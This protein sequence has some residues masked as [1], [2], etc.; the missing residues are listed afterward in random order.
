MS[1]TQR[2]RIKRGK[3]RDKRT[4]LLLLLLV[5]LTLL[6]L[7][8]PSEPLKKALNISADGSVLFEHEGL[9]IS[10][11]MSVNASALPDENGNFPD[12]L[13]LWNSTE[14]EMNLEGISLSN[15]SDKA[16]FIFPD[17]VLP[18]DGRV[19]IYC[20]K[21]NASI[22]GSPFHAKFK[23]SSLGC[24][25]FVFDPSGF[26]LNHVVVPTL[27]ANDSYSLMEDGSF[28][29]VDYYSPG[30][31][32]TPEGHGQYMERYTLREGTLLI[33]E[34]IA[35]P[36][37]GF[38]D[39]DGDL[40]DW[41]ELYNA[42]T[43]SIDLSN[44]ALSDNELRPIKWVFPEGSWI[45]PGGYYLV[46]CSGKNKA[47]PSAFPH[48][49]FSIAA[50]GETITLSSLQGNLIDRVT[51]S[52]LPADHSYG[53]DPQTGTW[54]VFAIP[55]PGAPNNAD[56][57]GLADRYLRAL[58]ETGVYVSELMSSN[59]QTEPVPGESPCDWVEL[60]NSSDQVVDL[61]GFGLS[62]SISWP[63]RWRFPA[64]VSIWPGE[65][66]IVMLDKS[67]TPGTNAAAL[68]ASFALKRAGG[69]VMT[70]SNPEGRV[71][72]R[73]VLPEIPG[74]ISYGR[75]IGR[76]GFFYYDVP[77]PG[78]ANGI[79]FLGFSN[80]PIL[81]HP[82]GLYGD[83]ILLTL[84]GPETAQ[85]RYTIDGSI[86][87]LNNSTEYQGPIEL[88]NTCV[89]R[90]RSFEPGLQPSETVTATYVLKTYY[91]LP[92][93]CLTTDPDEL[94][95]PQTGMYAA[96]EGIDVRQYEKI[97]FKNPSPVYR[98]HGKKHRPG[99]AEMFDSDSGET[100]LSQ[101][102]T[103]G[104]IGQYSLDMPQKSF[105]VSARGIYGNKTFEAKLFEDRP[106]EEYRSFVLRVS[107]N[108]CV[109]TRMVDGVQSRL[110][111]KLNTDVIHQAWRPVIVYLNGQYWGHYN[112]R[113]RVSRYFVAQHEG[114][115]MS[116]ADNMTILEGNGFSYYGSP[117][118]YKE[119]VE[120]AKT[121]SPGKNPEDLEYLT[122][123]ID[124]D[125][126]FDYM[127]LE[128]F[129]ANTDTGNIRFYKLP[130][131]KWRWILFD[132][133]YGLFNSTTNGIKV[134]LNPKGTGVNHAISNVLIR[135][136]LENSDMQDKFL[137]RF[138]EIFRALTTPV[139]LAQIDECY[140]LLEPE[141]PMHFERWASL[142]LKS[143][144]SDQPQT[145]DGCLRYWNTRVDRLRNVVRKRPTF[146]YD[147]VKDWFSLSDAQM[148]AYF[149]PRPEL[150]PDAI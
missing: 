84:S 64:G 74:N 79:G 23:L 81:S 88:S 139:M 65:Y 118:E 122:D 67:L 113:E 112:L 21:T 9:V 17:F 16:K 102:V 14:S 103:F 70:L 146:C 141:M 142:N 41:I 20:D 86:P 45:A 108:D 5:P 80:K 7:G 18:A 77:T 90:A 48:S 100:F 59:N 96:G 107:G 71:L 27:N 50:E 34:L 36:R 69:E 128:A 4:L 150:P 120:K 32:N 2:S 132:L 6:I 123:R 95:N 138:G 124:I 98:L 75:T 31:P 54:Q 130:G 94:W 140:A 117:A 89:I 149:G 110:V 125:N 137:R 115:P 121:L 8:S 131:G 68:H 99:F 52:L 46:F 119:L 61:S 66:K 60:Y 33:N 15:R 53:R 111:D 145:V 116:E 133:D 87:T 82:G 55:T 30:Y 58:N 114:I 13:E 43:E 72:D 1:A 29:I 105:K 62:D 49:N 24:A 3:R 134:I 35:A 22:A 12:W 109:W 39:E 148:G 37:S 83:N 10:E 144:S 93:V 19:L 92:V 11:V 106:F 40:S 78:S 26:L 51:F 147:Q 76:D 28:E 56:G 97:P 104:L 73:I 101:G 42:G 136:I 126:Y 57:M 63:R 91:T 129:F 143:I 44:Y 25:A 135:K 85:L 38:R 47:D 127:I